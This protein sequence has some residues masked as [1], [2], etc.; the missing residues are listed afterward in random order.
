MRMSHLKE[1]I[2][3]GMLFF[4]TKRRGNILSEGARFMAHVSSLKIFQKLSILDQKARFAQME[5]IRGLVL[6]PWTSPTP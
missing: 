3:E 2:S 4:C 1:K 5:Q 6:T